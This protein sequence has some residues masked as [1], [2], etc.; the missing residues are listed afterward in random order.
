M[1]MMFRDFNKALSVKS[2]YSK[3]LLSSAV[4]VLTALLSVSF[5]V[6]EP[7]QGDKNTLPIETTALLD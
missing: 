6:H 5:L 1:G 3:F 7:L 2:C 4:F